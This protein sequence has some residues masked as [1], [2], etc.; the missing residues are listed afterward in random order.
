M[1]ATL[2][3]LFH[4]KMRVVKYLLKVH[5]DCGTRQRQLTEIFARFNRLL[6]EGTLFRACSPAFGMS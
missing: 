3:D 2:Q 6:C 4:A 1:T 5:P